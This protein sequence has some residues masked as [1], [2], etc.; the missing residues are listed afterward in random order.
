MWEGDVHVGRL[1]LNVAERLP[2]PSPGHRPPQTTTPTLVEDKEIA[3]LTTDLFPR[4][5]ALPNIY[6]RGATG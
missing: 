3:L 1:K 5:G 4:S 6:K 2:V